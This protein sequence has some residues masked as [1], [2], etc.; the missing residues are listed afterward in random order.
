MTWIRIHFIPVQDPDR[1]QNSMNPK[2]WIQLIALGTPG[3][4]LLQ[5][6]SDYPSL[7]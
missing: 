6:N 5:I 4:Q 1:H 2:H 7:P 3:A